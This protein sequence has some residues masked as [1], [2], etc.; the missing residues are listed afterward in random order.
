MP[1][2]AFDAET[3]WWSFPLEGEAS[4]IVWIGET[5]R[6]PDN[7]PAFPFE[8]LGLGDLE[9]PAVPPEEPPADFENAGPHYVEDE[10]RWQW[11]E[12]AQAFE[13]GELTTLEAGAYDPSQ[14]EEAQACS[15]PAQHPPPGTIIGGPNV[16]GG[17]HDPNVPPNNWQSDNAV[18]IWL[19]PGTKVR[20]CAAGRVSTTY[21]YGYSGPPESRFGGYRL[22]IEHPGGMISFYQHLE[23]IT[24]GRGAH[25]KRGKV[26]GRSGFGNC[27]PHLHF[28]V[29]HPR[30]PLSWVA[31]TY[32]ANAPPNPPEPPGEPLPPPPRIK[33]RGPGQAWHNLMVAIG[34]DRRRQRNRLRKARRAAKK[35]LE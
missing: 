12:A 7:P 30:N 18:D 5:W 25:V 34:P 16:P 28:A 9:Q 20:A 29:T 32:D 24:I 3:G 4:P 35:A 21:G 6:G 2:L 19:Y 17:T 33:L 27:V 13:R 11:Y 1:R 22:H 14:Y 26:V 15:V 23:K 10:L 8:Q 31:A